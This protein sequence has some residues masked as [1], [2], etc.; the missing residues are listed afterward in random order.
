MPR[1]KLK[2]LVFY[3]HAFSFV[4]FL[5]SE[6]TLPISFQHLILPEKYP[7]PTELLDLQPLPLN[8]LRNEEYQRLYSDRVQHFNPIQ[9]QVF[10]ALYNM[11]ENVFIGAPNGSGKTVCAEFAMLRLFSQ[12]SEGRVVYVNPI[13]ALAQQTYEDWKLKFGTN[14]GRRVVLLTGETATDLKLIAK[15]NIIVS[16][17]EKWDILSRRWKQRKNVQATNLFIADEVQF[18]GGENGPVLEVVCSRMRYISSQLDRPIRI[19]ALSTSLSNAKDIASWLGCPA[20]STFNF[21]PNVRPIPLELHIQGINISHAATRLAAMV[22]PMYQAIVRHAGLARPKP[23]I[24]F[25][26]NR[27]L[28]KTTAIDILKYATA[29]NQATRFRQLGEEDLRPFVDRLQ[30]KVYFVASLRVFSGNSRDWWLKH[31]KKSNFQFKNLK[32]LNENLQKHTTSRQ[33]FGKFFIK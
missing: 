10:N 33:N 8:A 3:V 15:A 20:S 30:E 28:C 19:V 27:K 22:K 12:N 17:P 2:N 32:V 18:I 24:V 9:T 5:A 14:L 7:P 31:E 26:P 13:E 21:H 11:D 23:V 6:T 1:L 4:C 25:V 29:D 16:T